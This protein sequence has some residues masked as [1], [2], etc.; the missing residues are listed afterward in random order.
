MTNDN[1][2]MVSVV[3]SIAIPLQTS[4]EIKFR[5]LRVLVF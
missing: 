2:M 5:K 1:S 4:S 3:T